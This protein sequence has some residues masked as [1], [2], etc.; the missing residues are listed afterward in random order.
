MKMP[1]HQPYGLLR[2]LPIP[3]RPWQS[4]S[5]DFITDLPV[6][7]S[8]ETILIVVDHFT[9]MT[10]FLLCTKDISSEGIAD[11]LLREV[12]RHHGLPDNMISDRGPQF[13]C[14]FWQH[15]LS[16]FKVSWNLSSSYHPQTDG[17]TERTNQTLEQYL[18]CFI[19]YQQDDWG[20]NFIFCKVRL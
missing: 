10:H 18:R 13:V 11:L 19:N 12:F 15:L 3:N 17:Q 1:R 2:P 4:I 14:K 20:I 6:S 9:K 16:L 8:F 5:L 7:N